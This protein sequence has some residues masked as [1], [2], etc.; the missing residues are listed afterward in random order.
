[1]P[2]VKSLTT[3]LLILAVFSAL[4]SCAFIDPNYQNLLPLAEKNPAPDA[5]VGMWHRK[6]TDYLGGMYRQSY[7]FNRDG[8]GILSFHTSDFLL[9]SS[10]QNLS[11]VW[12]YHGGG[13]WKY[14]QEGATFTLRLSQGKLL[15]T[16][17]ISA[18]DVLE[19]VA[20]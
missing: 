20:E 7:L 11:L 5:I 15:R 19:K 6:S 10:E 12:K 13:I 1:M 4:T 3:T 2:I 14:T 18:F 16:Y 9:G 17:G 8:T